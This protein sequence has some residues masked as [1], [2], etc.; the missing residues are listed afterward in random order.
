MPTLIVGAAVLILALWAMNVY[1]KADPK[2]L[3]KLSTLR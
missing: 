3:A 1:S 2:M